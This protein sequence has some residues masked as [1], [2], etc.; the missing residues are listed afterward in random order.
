MQRTRPPSQLRILDFQHGGTCR[1]AAEEGQLHGDRGRGAVL[2]ESWVGVREVHEGETVEDG[3][4]VA[5]M[6]DCNKQ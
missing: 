4:G 6:G 1:C 5:T 2:V 3:G